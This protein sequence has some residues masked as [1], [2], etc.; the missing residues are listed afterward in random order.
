MYSKIDHDIRNNANLSL[1]DYCL[2]D[3]IHR[4]STSGTER[5]T[6]WCNMPKKGFSFLASERT[7]NNA[8]TRLLKNGWLEFYDEKR[9]LKRT[10]EKYNSE[11]F[12]YISGVKKLQGE[13]VA[14]V[15]KLHGRGE[16]VAHLGVKKLQGKGEKVAPNNNIDNNIKN[17]KEEKGDTFFKK[18]SSIKDQEKNEVSKSQKSCAKK[19]NEPHTFPDLSPVKSYDSLSE[20]DCRTNK[21]LPFGV[22]TAAQTLNLMFPDLIELT[23]EYNSIFSEKATQ[24]IVEL[25]KKTFIEKRFSNNFGDIRTVSLLKEVFFKWIVNQVRFGRSR[26]IVRK[27]GGSDTFKQNSLISYK[28]EKDRMMRERSRKQR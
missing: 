9:I 11:V 19:G 1:L 5:Y 14:P 6:N 28:E 4:L 7:I 20:F 22:V 17:N 2:L 10:T 16:K 27:E 12:L 15:K 24:E 23:R 13:K 21:Q 3:C 8:Y 18:S 26:K 25:A